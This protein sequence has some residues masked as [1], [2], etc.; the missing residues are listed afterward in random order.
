M[1]ID[2]G[3]IIRLFDMGMLLMCALDFY[4]FEIT[5]CAMLFYIRPFVFSSLPIK[6][7]AI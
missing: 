7:T 2:T 1:L 4:F 3:A 5:S 6:S